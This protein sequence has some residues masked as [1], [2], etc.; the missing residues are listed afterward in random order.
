MV[1]EYHYAVNHF[2]VNTQRAEERAALG[3]AAC[4]GPFNQQLVA[5]DHTGN[6]NVSKRFKGMKT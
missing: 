3:S 4:R 2:G 6:S 5:I 1:I